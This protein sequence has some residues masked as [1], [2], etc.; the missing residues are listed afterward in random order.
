MSR[1][2]VRSGIHQEGR[3]LQGV[4]GAI[5]LFAPLVLAAAGTRVLFGDRESAGEWVRAVPVLSVWTLTLGPLGLFRHRVI[6]DRGAGTLTHE[7]GWPF[8]TWRRRVWPLAG[9][10]VDDSDG[11][12]RSRC[13]VLTDGTERVT[14]R[15]FTFGLHAWNLAGRVAE[16][17][18]QGLRRPS[19]PPK[20]VSYALTRV[21]INLGAVLGLILGTGL[22]FALLGWTGPR[23]PASVEWRIAVVLLLWVGSVCVCV[24]ALTAWAP[25]VPIGCP[26]CGGRARFVMRLRPSYECRDC[27]SGWRTGT[28]DGFRG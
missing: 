15:R 27:G 22:F 8:R 14:I 28:S 5:A 7:W 21:L 20:I 18:G 6:P 12:Q 24:A 25:F 1:L 17:L 23:L 13:V 19:Q 10:R 3:F 2:V 26:R 16:F 4:L 9:F 11:A